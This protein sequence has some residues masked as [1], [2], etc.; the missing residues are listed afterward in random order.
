[1]ATTLVLG[2]RPADLE[3]YYV[4][5]DSWTCT[6][7][8]TD[9]NDVPIAWPAAPVIEH[10]GEASDWTSTLSASNSKATWVVSEVQVAALDAATD[11]RVRVSVNGVTWF[12]G[13]AIPSA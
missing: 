8:L 3:L 4:P 10:L 11:R 2:P 5:G 1:M 12:S 13:V 6:L 7:T 9:A